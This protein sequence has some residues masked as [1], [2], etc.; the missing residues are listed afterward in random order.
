MKTFIP[1]PHQL[2]GLV[3]NVCRHLIHPQAHNFCTL[4]L[5]R[6]VAKSNPTAQLVAEVVGPN[7]GVVFIR[8]V[9]DGIDTVENGIQVLFVRCTGPG[10]A[11]KHLHVIVPKPEVFEHIKGRIVALP[12]VDGDVEDTNA[13]GTSRCNDGVDATKDSFVVGAI[14]QDGELVVGAKGKEAHSVETCSRGVDKGFRQPGLGRAVSLDR[15]IHAN[16]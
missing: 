8:H 5:A 1:H 14:V 6:Q 9:G 12:K 16:F 11:H 3:F 15:S 4:G 13:R 7:G 2:L 10:V